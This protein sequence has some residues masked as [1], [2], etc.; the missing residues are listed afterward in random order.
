[1]WNKVGVDVAA[2]YVSVT[3][4]KRATVKIVV[5]EDVQHRIGENN[6]DH[7][8]AHLIQSNQKFMLMT[9]KQLKLVNPI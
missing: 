9:G 4:T 3:S 7:K 5:L 8:A 2:I 1:M 6:V